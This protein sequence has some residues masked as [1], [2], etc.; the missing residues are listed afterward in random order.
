MVGWNP[1]LICRDLDF[2]EVATQESHAN[3]VERGLIPTMTR[4]RSGVFSTESTH[5]PLE[6]LQF[7]TTI[8]IQ[9]TE[10]SPDVIVSAVA[11]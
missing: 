3:G 7:P 5:N 8:K 10:L 6:S 1:N 9:A 11:A 2:L 4:T